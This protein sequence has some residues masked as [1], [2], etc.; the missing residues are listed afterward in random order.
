MIK[1]K[2]SHKV[3]LGHFIDAMMFW[4]LMYSLLT[5]GFLY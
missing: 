1:I 2:Q 4:A 5:L 3:I